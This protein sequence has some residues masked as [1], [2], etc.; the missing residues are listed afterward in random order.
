[1]FCD[2]VFV[3]LVHHRLE[4]GGRVAKA[5]KHDCGFKKSI[6][7]FEGCLVFVTLFD[8]DIVITPSYIQFGEYG[9]SPKFGEEVRNEREGVLVA[10]CML[11]K[12]SVVM[13][14]QRLRHGRLFSFL[15]TSP[16]T[17]PILTLITD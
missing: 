9:H 16:L 3:N 2:D 11:V 7:C 17:I 4:C 15:S 6:A 13:I 5:K 1:M 14:P 10:N 8:A 12:A